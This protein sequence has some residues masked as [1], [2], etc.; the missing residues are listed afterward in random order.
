MN[1]RRALDLQRTFNFLA[2]AAP[3]LWHT[4]LCSSRQLVR[5][6]CRSM[7][8][9]CAKTFLVARTNHQTSCHFFSKTLGIIPIGAADFV[10][11]SHKYCACR[12]RSRCSLDL[13][14]D[15]TESHVGGDSSIARGVIGNPPYVVL[16]SCSSQ[17]RVLK[18]A[19]GRSWKI[20]LYWYQP[21]WR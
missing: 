5:Q 15:V 7:H 16:L 17:G 9:I 13:T 20:R 19:S 3:N 12:L 11:T 2:L 1:W 21:H 6:I 14:R 10:F 8:I 18:G 4:R